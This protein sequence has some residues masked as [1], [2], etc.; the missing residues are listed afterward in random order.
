M[1]ARLAEHG[2]KTMGDLTARA[3]LAV[4]ELIDV[5]RRTVVWAVTSR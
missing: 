2:W 1:V 5:L 3:Y 4:V